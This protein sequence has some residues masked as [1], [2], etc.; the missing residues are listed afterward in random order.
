MVATPA[1]IEAGAQTKFCA[2]LL[3][4]SETLVMTVTL[5]SQEKRTVL[6]EETTSTEFHTCVQF[7]APFVQENEVQNFKV[8]VKGATFHSEE[9]RKVMIKIYQPVTFIQTDKPI[10]LPGQTVHFRVITPDTKFRPVSTLPIPAVS[11]RGQGTPWTSLQSLMAE[12]AMQGVVNVSV[13]AEAVASHMSCDNEIVSVPER[14]RIDVVT[15]PLIVKAEGTEMTKAY[16]WLLCPK[17][18]ILGR[19]L[20]NLDGLLKMPTVQKNNHHAVNR[21]LSCL[22]ESISD[23]T[24]TYTTALLAYVFTLAGDMETRAHLLEQLDKVALNQGH[25]GGSSGSGSLLHSGVQSG[26]FKHSDSPVLQ[27]PADI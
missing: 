25:S 9:V 19:A 1:V 11:G 13:T 23:L 6:F 12:A 8:E 26:G 17:G 27:W 14:G 20:R 5:I 15:R 21:S 16:N 3:Q 2:S 24:N 18:D 10:Y 7:Q 4:P 22:N